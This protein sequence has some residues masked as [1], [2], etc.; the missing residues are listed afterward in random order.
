[1]APVNP[2]VVKESVRVTPSA[3]QEEPADANSLLPPLPAMPPGKATLIGGTV[4]GLDRVR[5]QFVVRAFG[6][7]SMKVLFDGRTQFW[8]DGLKASSRDLSN[9]QKVY[10][11]TVLD[12][13]TIFAKNIRLVA[14]GSTGESRGQ[15]V[16]FDA[17]RSEMTLNDGL[18]PNPF[19]VRI[20]GGTKVLREGRETSTN[21]LQPGT[22][23]QLQFRP[24]N[25]GVVLA[26]Q[27]SILAAPGTS[28]IFIGHVIFLDMQKGLLVLMDPRDK[29]TYEVNFNPASVHIN[30]DLQLDCD[31]TV[32][33][34][35]DGRRYATRSILV[36][37]TQD[38]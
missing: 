31:V 20:V 9:G 35:F 37:R 33:A 7:T 28:F 30:G 29:K 4:S 34:A 19:K 2:G 1:M 14:H 26:Q 23:V 36:N 15:I 18:S 10:V 38:R 8:R 17:A 21:A 32:D 5:D 12:G 24:D 11:D 27:I 22:L 25:E 16:T 13:T 3:R 6:G